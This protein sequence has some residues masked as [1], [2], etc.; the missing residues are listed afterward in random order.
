MTA[1]LAQ[2]VTV[3]SRQ[4]PVPKSNR[5]ARRRQPSQINPKEIVAP[6]NPVTLQDFHFPRQT[7]AKGICGAHSQATRICVNPLLWATSLTSCTQNPR[8]FCSRI[9]QHGLD[10]RSGVQPCGWPA[11]R[12]WGSAAGS[13]PWMISSNTG[14][15]HACLPRPT[16]GQVN[17]SGW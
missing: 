12:T 13:R 7:P 5:S 15:T 9:W 14:S 11:G 8:P 17:S 4:A 6:L 3:G 16:S 10:G 2:E 1:D